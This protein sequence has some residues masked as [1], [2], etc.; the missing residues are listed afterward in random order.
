M[1]GPTTKRGRRCSGATAV[2]ANFFGECVMNRNA[3][4]ATQEK[5]RREAG[6]MIVRQKI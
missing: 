1:P 5:G 6:L 3:L 2:P 4:K